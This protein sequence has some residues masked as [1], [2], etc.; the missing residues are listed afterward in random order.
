METKRY[1]MFDEYNGQQVSEV[2]HLTDSE[3]ELAR[4]AIPWKYGNSYFIWHYND[5]YIFKKEDVMAT[6]TEHSQFLEDDR[7]KKIDSSRKRKLT[8]YEKLKK[9]LEG[10]DNDQQK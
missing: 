10:N 9:E 6:L 5:S 8:L 4:A 1:A 2:L 7:N 3:F